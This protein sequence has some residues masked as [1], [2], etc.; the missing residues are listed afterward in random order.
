[1]IRRGALGVVAVAA[2]VGTVACQP[3]RDRFAGLSG[4]L[5]P[6]VF[7]PAQLDAAVDLSGLPVD[8]DAV[9]QRIDPARLLGTVSAL[10]GAPRPGGSANAQ[11]AVDYID[12][13]LAADGYTVEHQPVTFN[14]ATNPNVFA[15]KPG[16]VCPGTVF[17]IGGHYD[18]VPAGPGADDNATGV[19]GMLELA[20]VLHD[21]PLPISV[22]FTSFAFEENGLVGSSA[23][24]QSLQAAGTPVAGMVSLEMLGYTRQATD[25]FIG[26]NQD[27]LAMIGNPAST[28]LAQVF[29][30]AAL[31]AVPYHFA[32]SAAVDPSMLGDILRSDHAPFWA[33]G[34]PALLATD[35]ANFRN[36]NYHTATD[37]PAT[38]DG[39]FLLGSTKVMAA[40]LVAYATLD[41]DHD[42][43]PDACGP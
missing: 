5:A 16:T 31:A 9:V 42:G 37:T 1:M 26:T 11:A 39:P 28:H 40:G 29:G 38:L 27:F 35:E 32:P 17:V 22:R 6:D 7:T 2:L 4:P 23:M 41:A 20:R 24:A 19:A 36:P 30:A 10:A 18:S 33:R 8:L 15:T 43:T 12:G 3:A 34:Y 25:P 13:Q 21:V 14:G